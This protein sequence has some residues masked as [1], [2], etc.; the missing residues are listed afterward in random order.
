[1]AEVAHLGDLKDEESD[2]VG[3]SDDVRALVVWK[4]WL[5]NQLDI[6]S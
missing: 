1:M 6:P 4:R 2:A 3:D 5:D